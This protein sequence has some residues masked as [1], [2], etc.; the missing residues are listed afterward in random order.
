LLDDL[1]H[2]S[3]VRNETEAQHKDLKKAFTYQVG[4]LVW[5]AAESP[6][7]KPYGIGQVNHRSQLADPTRIQKAISEKAKEKMTERGVDR[8]LTSGNWPSS[9]GVNEPDVL[10]RQLSQQIANAPQEWAIGH[11]EALKFK[12]KAALDSCLGL[13]I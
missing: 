6:V 5:V 9:Y 10:S 13:F 11:V 7:E 12:K 3:E 8:F 4:D 2:W 1:G